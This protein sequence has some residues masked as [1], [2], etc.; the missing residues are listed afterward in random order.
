MKKIIK[1][2]IFFLSVLTLFSCGDEKKE[3]SSDT[4]IESLVSPETISNGGNVLKLQNQFFSIPSPIQTAIL[5]RKQNLEYSPE[6]VS[7]TDKVDNYLSRHKK[8]LNLGVLGSD[9]AY[10]SNYK[11]IKMSLAC[12]GKIE[13]LAEDL[14][15]KANINPSILKRFNEN[16]NIPDSLNALNAEFYKNAER[17]LKDNLQNEL[18]ALVLTGGWIES[19]HFAT[20]NSD[21]KFLRTR[22]AEQKNTVG[23]IVNIMASFEGKLGE[24]ISKELRELE[25]MFKQVNTSYNY[26]KPITDKDNKMTYLK[27][28]S[29]I[30][31]SDQ[32][33]ESIKSAVSRI[34]SLIIS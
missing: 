21:N 31:I 5:I 28:K 17:Y 1:T 2:S 30:E 20:Q 26:V 18:A 14:D 7:G 6:L 27:G 3:E 25:A 32:Q 15:I 23:N 13:A 22:V 10:L 33:L 12:L 34:R 24:A 16:I 19:L 11:D 8:A 9:L 29:N 4:K